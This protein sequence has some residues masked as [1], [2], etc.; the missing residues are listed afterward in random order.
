MCFGMND[1]AEPPANGAEPTCGHC[2]RKQSDSG[3]SIWM[4]FGELPP[5]QQRQVTRRYAPKIISVLRTK[6]PEA[7]VT[8]DAE[9]PPS[10]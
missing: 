3:W 6:W 8:F 7:T 1:A 10:V 4:P 2:G 9:P 5:K